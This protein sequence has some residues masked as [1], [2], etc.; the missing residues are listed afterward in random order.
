M[1]KSQPLITH[2]DEASTTD[3]NISHSTR[4]SIYIIIIIVIYHYIL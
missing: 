3:S 1:A 2:D 4:T